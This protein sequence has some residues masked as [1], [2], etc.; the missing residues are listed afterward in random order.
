MKTNHSHRRIHFTLIELLVVVAII[1]IL[2][3][4]LLPVLSQAREK[5]RRTSCA[6]NLKQIG[7]AELTYSGDFNGYINQGAVEL[8][9]WN[10]VSTGKV[11]DCPSNDEVLTSPWDTNSVTGRGDYY[12]AY[13]WKDDGTLLVSNAAYLLR[14]SALNFA[15]DANTAYPT[16]EGIIGNDTLIYPPGYS[17]GNSISSGQSH[18]AEPQ[19]NVQGDWINF[20]LLDGHVEGLKKTHVE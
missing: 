3:G 2:A 8:V 18:G 20:L 15:A 17:L 4:M 7:I 16:S 10:Y 12:L 5:A 14:G 1:A 6:A 11:W 9:T 13:P 19:N